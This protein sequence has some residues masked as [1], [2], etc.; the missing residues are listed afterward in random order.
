MGKNWVVGTI[1]AQRLLSCLLACGVDLCGSVKGGKF[2]TV[3]GLLRS[4]SCRGMCIQGLDRKIYKNGIDV[5][6]SKK[7]GSVSDEYAQ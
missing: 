2:E 3:R 7:E 5:C 4:I 1:L 6:Y